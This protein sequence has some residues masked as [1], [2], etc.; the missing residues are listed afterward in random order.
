MVS[1]EPMG[2]GPDSVA[3]AVNVGADALA[4]PA[5]VELNGLA[6]PKSSSL[7][8]DLVRITFPGFRSR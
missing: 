2:L 5:G 1:G 7:A 8:P 4:L 6:S 3:A